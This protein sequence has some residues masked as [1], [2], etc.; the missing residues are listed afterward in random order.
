MTVR[1]EHRGIGFS[2]SALAE[3]K[4]RWK[5]HPTKP[6]HGSECESGPIISGE[7]SGAREDAATAAMKAI[8]ARLAG[9]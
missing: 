7:V 5:L 3:S 4:W 2:I 1:D 8:D 6:T 9:N